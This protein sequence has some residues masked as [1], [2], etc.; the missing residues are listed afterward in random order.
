M[1][2]GSHAPPVPPEPREEKARGHA[3]GALSSYNYRLFFFGQGAS[4]CGNWM[5]R[6]AQ[7]WLVL[8]LTGSP[9]ALG[10]VTALQTLPVMILSLFGGVLADRLPKRQFLA[11]VM[12]AESV[13][14]VIMAALTI[15][16][17]V[18]LWE[19]YVLAFALGTLAAVETPVRQAFVS[20]TVPIRHMQSAIVLNSTMFNAARIVGPGVAGV[21]IAAWGTGVCFGLNAASF[22]AVVAALLVMRPSQLLTPRHTN[23]D[24]MWTQLGD[25]LRYTLRTREL[26]F[27][28]VLLAFIGTLG[29]NYTVTLPLI[30]RFALNSGAV[31]FGG[32]DVAMGI[33]ALTAGVWLASRVRPTMKSI[34]VAGICFSVIF[35]PLAASHLYA[36]SFVLLIGL[37]AMNIFYN[38]LT[39]TTL[40]VESSPEYRGRVM[41]VFILLNQ[42]TTPIG[43]AL[44]GWLADSLGIGATVALEGAGCLLTAVL[45]LI[46][47]LVSARTRSASDATAQL[48]E[49]QGPDG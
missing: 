27:P 49:A 21:I 33:G 30:A 42:G 38:T 28:V 24:A 22:I 45:G 35:L 43:G 41:G 10:I 48:A 11:A 2:S 4:Q 25:G 7:A 36:L 37:G 5:Q 39:N 29:L 17:V 32:L 34:A 44:T 9:V 19:I 23:H 1:L 26:L 13:Q 12:V 8:E 6:T 16:G 15:A 46:Y 40:Q 14:A 31:A 3:L 18:Q 20:E 47:A